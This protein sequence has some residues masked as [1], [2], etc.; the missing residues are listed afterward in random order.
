MPVANSPPD[1]SA[2]R[3]HCKVAGGC[4]GRKKHKFKNGCF[5]MKT[6]ASALLAF[7]LFALQSSLFGQATGDCYDIHCPS[8]IFSP[9]EG[10]WGAHVTYSVTTSNRC[11]P[12][13]P[14]TV[15]YS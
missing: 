4:S 14:P 7:L 15:T 10:P 8:K 2:M 6:K 11:D 13:L 12:A 9:C 3:R 1:N 5:N